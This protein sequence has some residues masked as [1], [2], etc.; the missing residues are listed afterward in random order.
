MNLNE[1]YITRTASFFPN[2][3]VSNDEME[4]FLGVIND[5]TSKSRRIVLRNNKILNRFYAIQPDGTPTHSNSEMVALAVR[6]LFE[7]RPEELKEVDLLSCGTSSPDQMMPS[8]AVMVHGWLPDSN[9]IEVVSPAGVCCSGMHAFKYAYM[10]IKLGEKNKAISSGSERLSRILRADQFE[11]EV[12]RLVELEENPFLAFEKDFLRWM[13]SDGASTFLLENKKSETGVSLRVD[14]IE[15]F[16]FANEAEACMYM[17]ADK[18]PN[19]TLKSYM[20][21]TPTEVYEKS[22]LSIKQDVKLLG[23]NIVKLGFKKLKETI[24]KKGVDV[25]DV[26]YFLPHMSSHFFEDKIYDALKEYDIEIPKEKWFTNLSYQ[27]NVGAA[28]IY[29]MVDGLMNSGK[30]QL[31][32]KILLAVPESSRFS[33]VFSLLTVC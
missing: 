26:A 21:Y 13:L 17:A 6:K 23:E 29:M 27:G 2:E 3:P 12:K 4:T 31:G 24:V 16:S 15:G 5:Q 10:A 28:S 14:W 20:D 9:T 30:L 33:Y 11:L 32:D 7:N 19:G 18:N 22:I 25:K 8:H 1:V